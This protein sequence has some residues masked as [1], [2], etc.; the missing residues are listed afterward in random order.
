MAVVG[1]VASIAG[2]LLVQAQLKKQQELQRERKL[3]YKKN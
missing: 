1:G 2:G 3:D